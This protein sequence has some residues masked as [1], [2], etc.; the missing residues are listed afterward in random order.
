MIENERIEVASIDQMLRHM[1]FHCFFI[2]Y[3]RA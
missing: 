2:K 1:V 3:F